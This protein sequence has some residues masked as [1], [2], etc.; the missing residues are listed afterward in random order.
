MLNTIQQK[1]ILSEHVL[2]MLVCS[3]ET[4]LREVCVSLFLSC[5]CHTAV[6]LMWHG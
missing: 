1:P 6:S 5:P 2:C 3:V 4:G